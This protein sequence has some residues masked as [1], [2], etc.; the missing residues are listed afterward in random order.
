MTSAADAL[1]HTSLSDSR[2]WRGTAPTPAPARAAPVSTAEMASFTPS[3]K[4]LDDTELRVDSALVDKVDME[5][6]HDPPPA[7]KGRPEL[8]RSQ[9]R[10]LAWLQYP[11]RES[12]VNMRH[13]DSLKRDMSIELMRPS[14][15]TPARDMSMEFMHMARTLGSASR[16][17]SHEN[18]LVRDMSV[19]LRSIF[20]K[21]LQRDFSMNMPQLAPANANTNGTLTNSRN[22]IGASSD[23]LAL[24]MNAHSAGASGLPYSFGLAGSIEAFRDYNHPY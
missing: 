9:S 24:A 1:A 16:E 4:H 23:D 20:I 5:L 12:L 11:S 13:I 6:F 10:K 18:N 2:R 22:R 14:S 17:P 15:H 8:P 19:E 3:T 7:S 21:A